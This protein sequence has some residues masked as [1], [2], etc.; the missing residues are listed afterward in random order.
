MSGVIRR[1]GQGMTEFALVLPILLLIVFGILDL[2]R[3][4][5]YYVSVSEAIGEAGRAASLATNGMPTNATV[6]AAAQSQ[7][8]YLSLAPCPN[9]PVP[10]GSSSLPPPGVGWLYI[11]GPTS[12]PLNASGDNAPGGESA[13]PAAGSCQATAPALSPGDRLQVTVVYNFTPFTPLIAQVAGNRIV[14]SPSS[15]FE[16]EY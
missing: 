9:G 4:I 16:V 3:V 2:G 8:G 11:T 1:R 14:L 15:I 5:F 13:A 6:L 10:A 7:A 12:A